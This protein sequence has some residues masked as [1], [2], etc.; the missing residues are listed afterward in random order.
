MWL[1]ERYV[2]LKTESLCCKQQLYQVSWKSVRWEEKAWNKAY[3]RQYAGVYKEERRNT[4]KTLVDVIPVPIS[5]FT[6]MWKYSV[7]RNLYENKPFQSIH[8]CGGII[9]NTYVGWLQSKYT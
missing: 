2:V 9:K 6:F 5:C 8:T 3:L 1:E 7:I 4:M